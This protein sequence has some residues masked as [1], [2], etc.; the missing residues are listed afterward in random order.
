MPTMSLRS[1]SS[2][3]AHQAEAVVQDGAK[4]EEEVP[5]ECLVLPHVNEG[6]LALALILV[7]MLKILL[8]TASKYLP[9]IIVWSILT[10]SRSSAKSS[11]VVSK[12]AGS[13]RISGI[14]DL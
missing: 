10:S 3:C 11:S 5:K 6:A 4:A 9:I 8:N 12:F 2:P 13:A 7:I 1:N 14:I